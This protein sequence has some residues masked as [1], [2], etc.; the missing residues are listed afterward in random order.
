MLSSEYAGRGEEKVIA[1]DPLPSAQETASGPRQEAQGGKEDA[2]SCKEQGCCYQSCSQEAR[3]WLLVFRR[4]VF[5]LLL[6]KARPL[7][8]LPQ[9]HDTLHQD[10]ERV[11]DLQLGSEVSR[12]CLDCSRVCTDAVSRP[13]HWVQRSALTPLLPQLGTRPCFHVVQEPQSCYQKGIDTSSRVGRCS[14]PF[15][16]TRSALSPLAHVCSP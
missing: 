1:A 14:L 15:G 12:W 3:H 8:Q 13:S 9:A 11:L 7:L 4:V 16:G 6:V 5:L 2:R 10:L